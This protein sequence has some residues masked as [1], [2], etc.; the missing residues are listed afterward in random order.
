MLKTP[1][2]VND[3]GAC[4]IRQRCVWWR[5]NLNCY[6]C[7]KRPTP[8]FDYLKVWPTDAKDRAPTLCL[9]NGRWRSHHPQSERQGNNHSNE[10][11]KEFCVHLVPPK[12]LNK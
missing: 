11:V 5:V 4:I 2:W 9:N 1:I 3:F 10:F 12:D 8:T 7:T 6:C